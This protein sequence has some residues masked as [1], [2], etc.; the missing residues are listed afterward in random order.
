MEQERASAEVVAGALDLDGL[1]SVAC[2]MCVFGV[3]CALDSDDE[4]EVRRTLRFFV[5]LL[6]D[7][8]LDAPVR[9]AL[10]AARKAGVADAGAAIADLEARGPR[11]FVFMAVVRALAVRQ[12]EAM[13]RSYI[14]SQN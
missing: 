3:A 10:E 12:S 11:S 5:P 2:P 14:T 1:Q 4:Q 13:R 8:G 7:E 6:W 9:A